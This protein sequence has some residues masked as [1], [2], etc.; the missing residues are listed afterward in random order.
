MHLTRVVPRPWALPKFLCGYIPILL[1]VSGCCR[2]DRGRSHQPLPLPA[3]WAQDF[4]RTN[5]G[6]V[7]YRVTG[8]KT[9]RAYSV[10]R[11][12]FDIQGSTIP[13][14][15]VVDLDYFLPRGEGPWPV[16]MILPVSGGSYELENHFS[17]YFAKRGF[18]AVLVHRER[19]PKKDE[20]VE[21][22]DPMLR[23]TVRNNRRVVD[24]IETRPELDAGRIGVFGAS[25]GGIKGALLTPLE[26]RIHTAVLGLLGGDLPY[27]MAHSNEPG[28]KRRR[29]AL[30][31]QRHLSVDE[32][33][34]Y[35]RTLITFDPMRLA[36]YVDHERVLLVLAKYD[37]TVPYAKGKELREKM[38]N[39]ETVL[40]PA[41][42]YT[43][44]LYLPHIQKSAYKFFRRRFEVP[45]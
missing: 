7:D 3:V 8:V 15:K 45:R 42:H 38:G 29:K 36:P 33:E 10:Q 21:I 11:V 41:G 19:V 28:V 26:P 6:Q 44:L 24:W 14:N 5:T 43:A 39:P 12:S 40:V 1:L 35:L 9:N 27:V 25:L 16:I 20:F 31:E 13:G 22:L 17:K 18:A 2:L 34:A 37:R 4:A 30:M 23:Q 32:L